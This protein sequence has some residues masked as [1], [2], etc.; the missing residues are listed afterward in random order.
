MIFTLMHASATTASQLREAPFH[1]VWKSNIYNKL[2]LAAVLIRSKTPI[3]V[4]YP[5]PV[6]L[7]SAFEIRAQQV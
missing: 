5:R 2:F 4:V 3:I 7:C 6:N 1:I